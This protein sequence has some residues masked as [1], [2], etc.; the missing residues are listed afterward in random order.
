MLKYVW[1]GKPKNKEGDPQWEMNHYLRQRL[2][3]QSTEIEQLKGRC[4][5]LERTLESLTT[6]DFG[7]DYAPTPARWNIRAI[8]TML[9]QVLGI[10]GYD[11]SPP[12]SS[13]W[14]IHPKNKKLKK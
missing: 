8:A 12:G 5:Q 2:E 1:G 3:S 9:D 4:V 13:G 6:R 11:A 10:L 14:R 7:E